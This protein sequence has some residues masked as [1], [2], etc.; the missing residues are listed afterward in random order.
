MV[1]PSFFTSIINNYLPEPQASLLNGI[2]FG[3]NLKPTKIFYEQLKIVGL[4]HII[5][6]S[7]MNITILAAIISSL[8]SFF[9]KRV[10]IMITILMIILF[11]L[12]VGPKAPIIRA[13][14]MGSLTL[15]A[16]LTGRKNFVLYSLFLSLIFIAIVFPRWL[17]SISLFLSYG[18]TFGIVFFGQTPS[19]NWLIKEL[20]ITLSAQIFTV[21]IIF[22]YFKQ[23]SLIAPLSNVLV[24]PIIPPLMIFG[25][26]TAILGKINYLLGLIPSYI[27]YGLLTYMVWVVEILS[28]L[29][30][31]FIKF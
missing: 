30:F 20:K 27:C 5:V 25:F 3:I 22:I 24:A 9:S 7:G 2:L 1:N 6:L 14:L 12:F 4:L 29:S 11:I 15:V 19:K 23:I 17:T 16:I 28:K 13:G 10:S 31:M 8:T 21:P 26:L 18:A